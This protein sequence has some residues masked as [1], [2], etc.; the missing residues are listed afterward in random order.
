M[1]RTARSGKRRPASRG[2]AILFLAG[3]LMTALLLVVVL[4]SLEQHSPVQSAPSNIVRPGADT[5]GP[6]GSPSTVP[7]GS[8]PPVPEA[9][10]PPSVTPETFSFYD[11]LTQLNKQ[12]PNFVN[13][14]PAPERPPS[15]TPPPAAVAISPKGRQTRY[16]VQ[17]AALKERSAAEALATRLRQKNYSAF[18]LPHVVPKRGTWY[19]VRVGHFKKREKAQELAQRLSKQ[20]RLNTYVAVEGA[21]ETP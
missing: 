21:S 10:E 19:R 6:I 20:E 17:V 16:T 14:L 5:G 12:D 18:I 7:P 11:A 1:R 2:R 3:G 13:L 4:I 8:P 9:N 15:S